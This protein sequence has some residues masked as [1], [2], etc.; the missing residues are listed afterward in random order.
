[1]M[2]DQLGKAQE[3]IHSISAKNRGTL[4]YALKADVFKKNLLSQKCI[5][6]LHAMNHLKKSR[7]RVIS[8]VVV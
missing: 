5:P 4:H 3:I 1:M 8:A 2:N 7:A 6:L